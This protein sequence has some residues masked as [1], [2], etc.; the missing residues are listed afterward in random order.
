VSLEILDVHKA[1]NGMRSV[2]ITVT[3]ILLLLLCNFAYAYLEDY[4]SVNNGTFN[5]KIVLG[6]HAEVEDVL[7]A[8]DI[9]ASLQIASVSKTVPVYHGE[10]LSGDAKAINGGKLQLRKKPTPML[11]ANDIKAFAKGHVQTAKGVTDYEQYLRVGAT[12]LQ[13]ITSNYVENNDD[14]LNDYFVLGDDAPFFEWEIRFTDGLE[15]TVEEDGSLD[16]LEGKVIDLVG[17]DAKI[18]SATLE[19]DALTM[20]LMGGST[21]ATLL[22]GETGTYT[23]NG[24]DYEVTPVLISDPNSGTPEVKLSVNGEITHALAA[25]ET[26]LLTDGLEVGIREI[27]VNS[28]QGAVSFYLGARKITL[29]DPTVTTEN[30]DG[31]V[32]VNDEDISE[33]QIQVIGNVNTANS[34]FRIAWIKYR[35]TANSLDGSKVYMPYGGVLRSYIEHPEG[36]LSDIEFHY[37]G[38]LP[39]ETRNLTIIPDGDD[40]YAMTFSNNDAKR[41]SFPLLSNKNGW[42]YGSEDDDLVFVE[43]TSGADH[44]IGMDDY[45]ILSNNR[46]TADADKSITHVLRY[47][48]YDPSTLTLEFESQSDRSI[49]KVPISSSGIGYLIPGAQTYKVN[50]SDVNGDA[51]ELSIDLDAN[52]AYSNTVKIVTYGGLIINLGQS[53]YLNDSANS[54]ANSLVVG[55]GKV[56]SDAAGF[57]P[58][59]GFVQMS[60]Q[61]LGKRF[62]TPGIDEIFNWTILQADEID[63]QMEDTAYDGPLNTDFSDENTG[64]VMTSRDDHTRGLTDYGI[65]ID[66]YNPSNDPA[67]LVLGIPQTQRYTQMFVSI[68]EVIHGGSVPGTVVKTNPLA[69]GLAVTDDEATI[70]GQLIVIG[71]PCVNSIAAQLLKS[72]NCADGF[73][74][75]EARIQV[76][77]DSVLVAGYSGADTLAAARYLAKAKPGSLN[78]EIVTLDTS[79]AK[80][81]IKD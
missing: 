40:A 18:V 11:T 74:P 81:T 13:Q 46:G 33:G 52:G 30:F 25:G 48:D 22:E 58:G 69:V 75:G 56:I 32:E 3:T 79:G 57:T 12:G 8:I 42:K 2:R 21:D 20:T 60:A 72:A 59:S 5:G 29:I 45:F 4:P 27:L 19:G 49:L 16:D 10:V 51:P 14:V 61:V 73:N 41:Y 17:M 76:I 7:G 39:A 1:T 78:G 43:G 62:D 44:N 23:I 47:T 53:V 63:L 31:S 80:V 67:E 50:V 66:V 36:M 65:L 9:A 54:S 26:D 24:V 34:T 35:Y 70:G 64:F 77:D 6:K 71:G 15:S 28:R 55:D 68:G 37:H 38:L